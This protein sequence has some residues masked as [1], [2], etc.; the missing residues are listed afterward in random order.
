[1]Y[2]WTLKEFSFTI[3]LDRSIFPYNFVC[4]WSL[5]EYFVSMHCISSFV[6]TDH[7]TPK[8]TFYHWECTCVWRCTVQG[9]FANTGKHTP[10]RQTSNLCFRCWQQY[11]IFCSSKTVQRVPTAG[12]PWQKLRVGQQYIGDALPDFPRHKC[13]H[14]RAIMLRSSSPLILFTT[15]PGHT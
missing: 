15:K 3:T 5:A 8:K 13:L 12:N 6:Q 1:M 7:S 10:G 4:G 9:L 11:E 2:G 14:E